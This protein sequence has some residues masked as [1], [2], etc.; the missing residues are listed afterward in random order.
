VNCTLRTLRAHDS[1][2]SRRRREWSVTN[3]QALVAATCHLAIDEQVYSLAE[4]M[5]RSVRRCTYPTRSGRSGGPALPVR[6][7]RGQ[8]LT[9]NRLARRLRPCRLTQFRDAFRRRPLL[10][11]RF[12]RQTVK[13]RG[14]L[15]V[16]AGFKPSHGSRCDALVSGQAPQESRI[17]DGMTVESPTM[18]VLRRTV[19][20]R[21]KISPRTAPPAERACR[22]RHS[23]D[24]SQ[25]PSSPAPSLIFARDADGW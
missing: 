2:G 12:N 25:A 22:A 14:F 6:C 21:A 18:G 17:C 19:P 11:R 10:F 24:R 1:S 3:G 9:N 20:S 4:L 23:S 8:P 15:Q 16:F 13:R 5:S 7:N